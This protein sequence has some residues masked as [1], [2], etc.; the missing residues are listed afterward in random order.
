MYSTY[1]STYSRPASSLFAHYSS[2]ITVVV[3]IR[4]IGATRV[5]VPIS[6]GIVIA[7]GI[8]VGIVVA[9]AEAKAEIRVPVV[10]AIV[11]ATVITAIRTIGPVVAATVVAAVSPIAAVIA[12]ARVILPTTWV[13]A[14]AGVRGSTAALSGEAWPSR[15]TTPRLGSSL[16]GASAIA[17]PA[18]LRETWHRID[19]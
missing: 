9:V 11:A 4:V 16:R 3:A 8:A 10:A 14:R 5:R 13:A 6:I 7:V 12:W 19:K 15:R 2:L 18:V 17:A 1:A